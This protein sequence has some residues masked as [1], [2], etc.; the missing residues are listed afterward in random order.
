ML[1]CRNPVKKLRGADSGNLNR[2]EYNIR[3]S[4][5]RDSIFYMNFCN[6]SLL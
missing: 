6:H 5:E 1:R 2:A 3:P 4:E